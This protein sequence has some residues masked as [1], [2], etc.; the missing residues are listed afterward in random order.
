MITVNMITVQNAKSTK[1]LFFVEFRIVYKQL[2]PTGAV[3]KKP[4]ITEVI[5]KEPVIIRQKRKKEPVLS[6]PARV[7]PEPSS[8]AA[9]TE[10]DKVTAL[11]MRSYYRF[12]K[13]VAKPFEKA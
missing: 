9:V 5:K 12:G 1:S 13:W 3:P 6:L 8:E 10:R 7:V 4:V 2:A 11:V